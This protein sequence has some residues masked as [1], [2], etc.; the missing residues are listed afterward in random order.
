MK[1]TSVLASSSKR[2]QA[3]HKDRVKATVKFVR[4]D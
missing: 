3:R 1:N 4:I 2:N